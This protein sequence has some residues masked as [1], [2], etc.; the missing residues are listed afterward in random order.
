MHHATLIHPVCP[1]LK[2]A[3][4]HNYLVPNLCAEW[5]D[6]RLKRNGSSVVQLK[7]NSI[8][9]PETYF[10]GTTMPVRFQSINNQLVTI[11][12]SGKVIMRQQIQV[13]INAFQFLINCIFQYFGYC[14]ITAEFFPFDMHQCYIT[15]QH[16]HH[17]LLAT[18][19]QQSYINP[20]I[21]EHHPSWWIRYYTKY[22]MYC[23]N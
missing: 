17:N 3:V 5:Y 12:S 21:A 2:C 20:Y 23:R 10:F 16:E 1:N 8:W 14:Q 6:D 13:I 18:P 9:T 7:A 11:Y 22:I 4:T 19:K 15:I